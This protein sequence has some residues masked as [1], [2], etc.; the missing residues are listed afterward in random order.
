MSKEIFHKKFNP[1]N[2]YHE[3]MV[4]IFIY[5]GG[6]YMAWIFTI[7]IGVWAI[8]MFVLAE[9]KEEVWSRIKFKDDDN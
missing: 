7:L 2:I 9:N 4:D 1:L 3:Q 8:L 6:E 5:I